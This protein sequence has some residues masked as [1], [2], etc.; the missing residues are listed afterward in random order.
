MINPWVKE[1]SH[2]WNFKILL[3]DNENM[4]YQSLWDTARFKISENYIAIN[5][6]NRRREAKKSTFLKIRKK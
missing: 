1:K 3:N 6:N 5:V 4:T 2:S